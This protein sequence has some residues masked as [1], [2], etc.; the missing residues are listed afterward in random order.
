MAEIK[1]ILETNDF[2]VHITVAVNIGNNPTTAEIDQVLIASGN[3]NPK[4]HDVGFFLT[5]TNATFRMTWLQDL[6]AYV[7]DK[8]KT[9]A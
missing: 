1:D 3:E 2:T 8:L 9:S 4:I 5:A 6:G 7:Y